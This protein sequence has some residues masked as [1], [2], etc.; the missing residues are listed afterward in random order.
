MVRELKNPSVIAV[1]TPYNK[2]VLA[3]LKSQVPPNGRRW[4]PD[5]KVWL[6]S[7]QYGNT[8]ENILRSEWTGFN[9]GLTFSGQAA[10]EQR[11]IKVEYIG[12][13]KI[14]DDHSESAYAYVDGDWSYMFPRDILEN[15]FTGYKPEAPKRSTLYALLQVDPG[16]SSSEVTTGFRRMARLWHPDINKEPNAH[17]MF[18]R[19]K[20]AY[21]VLKDPKK[22]AKY[23]LGL[24]FELSQAKPKKSR[25][26]LH[27]LA[28]DGYRSPFTCGMV[29]VTVIP[30]VT[31][32]VVEIHA[33]KDV[34]DS[35]G[36]TMVTSW[37]VGNDWFTTNW[38]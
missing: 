30:S 5:R 25:S 38:V 7:D 1:R 36:R 19:I 8:V 4:D 26:D 12:M 14:R 15:Y 20:E 24:K 9:S 2:G 18:I 10:K 27:L 32:K 37:K 6:V 29:A 34:V 16:A 11:I 22:K 33:W 13:T 28:R 23:D 35:Q 3:D 17:D 21:D 31:N